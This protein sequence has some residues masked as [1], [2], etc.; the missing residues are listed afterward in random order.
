MNCRNLQPRFIKQSSIMPLLIA[1][2]KTA[3]NDIVKDL[4]LLIYFK[5]NLAVRIDYYKSN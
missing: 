2:I 5:Y 4:K 3:L 1:Q